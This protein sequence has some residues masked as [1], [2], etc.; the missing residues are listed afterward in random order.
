MP[1]WTAP[2]FKAAPRIARR[3]AKAMV[4]L[5]LKR[6]ASER[7]A[8]LGESMRAWLEQVVDREGGDA[9]WNPG[10]WQFGD[11]LDPTAPPDQPGYSRTD[12]VMVAD[13]YLVNVTSVFAKVCRLLSKLD[14]AERSLDCE[15]SNWYRAGD[16]L[17][18]V[19]GGE[20]ESQE[21]I[22]AAKALKKLVRAAQFKI[23]TGF[24]GT[25]LITHALTQTAQPQLAYQM[26]YEKSCPSYIMLPDESFNPGRMTSFNHY[27]LGAM[28]D[29]L[30]STV[31]GITPMASSPGW[32]I[33]R[34]KPIP[35]GN[36]TWAKTSF[37][38]PYGR[39][40]CK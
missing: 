12:S 23:G 19:R 11:W 36:L 15:Y 8:G 33:F 2:A 37:D 13:T 20:K 14:V 39:I 32:K 17:L 24:A 35:G 34:V 6:S 22:A 31:G 38:G 27:A 16:M 29:W 21:V 10:R 25:P 4:Y 7:C 3:E 30:H 40:E 5:R 28:A 26:L 1:T 9:L 18:I